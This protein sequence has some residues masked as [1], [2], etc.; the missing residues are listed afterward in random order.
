ME[1]GKGYGKKYR[2]VRKIWNNGGGVGILNE[3]LRENLRRK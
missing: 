2:R 3:W 1:G